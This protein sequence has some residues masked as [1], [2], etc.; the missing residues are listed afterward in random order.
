MS[1]AN[2]V[3]QLLVH[4]PPLSNLFR[5]LG[6]MKRHRGAGGP[7]TGGSATPLMDAVV[8]ILEEFGIEE[9]E[10]LSTQ[11]PLQYIAEGKPSEDE[12]TKEGHNTVDLLKPR[13]MYDAMKEKGRLK[14]LL[15]S[16]RD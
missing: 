9:K 4:S 5:E 10:S 2:A 12:Q 1:L 8:R 14:N 3:F 6:D 16:F 7:E 15:V 13:Y 11:Q